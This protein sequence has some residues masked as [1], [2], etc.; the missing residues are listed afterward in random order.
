MLMKAIGISAGVLG[1]AMLMQTTGLVNLRTAAE[2]AGILD[3]KARYIIVGVDITEGREKELPKDFHAVQDLLAQ[4]NSGDRIEVYLIYSRSESEQEAIFSTQMP[5]DPGP[6][7]LTLK[8][9]QK[10]AQRFLSDQWEKN[11]D[12]FSK[13]SQFVQQTDLFGFFRFV[14]NK[15]A[16]RKSDRPILIVYTDGQQVGDGF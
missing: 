2:E 14:S 11:I 15:P 5:E 6:M 16:F 3:A 1:I 9:A 13:S 4:S 10:T 7:G 12:R 8:R